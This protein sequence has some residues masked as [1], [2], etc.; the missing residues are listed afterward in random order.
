MLDSGLN[1]LSATG[2]GTPP[3]DSPSDSRG[4]SKNRGRILTRYTLPVY[5]G[6]RATTTRNPMTSPLLFG[7][8]LMR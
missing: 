1:A 8:L 7:S 6:A 3:L 2:G 4:Q 5:L